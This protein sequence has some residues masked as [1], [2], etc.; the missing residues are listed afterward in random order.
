MRKNESQQTGFRRV[1]NRKP[2]VSGSTHF[3]VRASRVVITAKMLFQFLLSFSEFCCFTEWTCVIRGRIVLYVSGV[4]FC[5]MNEIVISGNFRQ[6]YFF[7]LT[8][9]WNDEI[10]VKLAFQC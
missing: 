8:R 4:R 3:P 2:V 7:V 10:Q 9:I 5:F 6:F 1:I